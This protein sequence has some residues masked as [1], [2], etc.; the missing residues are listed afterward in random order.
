MAA[1]KPPGASKP[2]LADYSAKRDFSRTAE[3][4]PAPARPRRGKLAFV[5]QKHDARRL[6]FDLRL[7]LDGVL[8]SWAVTRG[9]SMTPG[10]R[11]LAVQTEDH[12]M[13]Y[14]AWEGVI[15]Q[16]QYGGGTMIVWDRGT[17]L[18]EGDARK[19][20]AKGRLTFR[21][22]GER[23]KGTWSLVRM[24]DE[25]K[26]HNWLLI[27]RSDENALA[28]GGAEPVDTDMASVISGKSNAEIAGGG[29]L[30]PDHK[31]RARKT[32][33][34]GPAALARVKGAKKDI[35]PP[36][37]APS[38]ALQVARPPARDGWI[39]EIK[40]DGYRIEARLDAGKV[41]LLTRKGLD[42]TRRFPTVA[43]AVK[44]LAARTALLD[45]E[46]IVQD[47]AG[48]TSF[49]GLQSDLKAGRHDRMVYYAFDLLH[50]DGFDL[51]GAPLVERKR[52][53]AEIIAQSPGN[54]ALRYNDHI[55]EA[56]GDILPQACRLG[57]E[58]IV[59]KQLAL[60]Y[61]SGRGEHWVKSKCMLR[62]EFVVLGFLPA[63]DRKDAVGSLVLGYYAGGRL[64]H[65]G[66]AGTG[67]SAD[68]ARALFNRFSAM[69]GKAPDFGNAVSRAAARGVVWV[70][71][72]AVAE[73]EYRGRTADGLLRQAAFVG[74]REDKPASE[75][76]LEQDPLFIPK[77]ADPDPDPAQPDFTHPERVMWPEAGVT[78]QDLGDYYV[79]VAAW[80][81]PHVSH[82]VLS[83]VR[84]PDGAAAQ[85][86]FAKHAW[87]GLD[88]AIHLADTGE[89]KPMMEIGDLRGLLALVQMNVLE[90]HVWGSRIGDLD[91]PDRLIFDLDPGEGVTWD[92]VKAS[93]L[94]MRDRLKE[95]G[96]RSFLKTSGGKGLHVTVPLLPDLD[97]DAAKAF[98]RLV[99]QQ[100]AADDPTRYVAT[101]AKSRRKGRIFIDYLRNGR[102]ATAVAP[103]STRAR[104]GAPVAMPIDW[105]EL[106]AL[107]SADHYTVKNAP[108]RLAKRDDPWSEMTKIRQKLKL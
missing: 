101:M 48:Q 14:K 56:G 53:L 105:S 27:K 29:D 6:H 86:F 47:E 33:V 31:A 87:M 59:S 63:S 2:Q 25:G 65:A 68:D 92:D 1:R 52:L 11:R 66:R 40:H 51:R 96:L 107:P 74:L 24:K 13:A 79:A 49:S 45:G 102:G 20:L 23:L 80:I 103:Y 67:F 97:W 73:I 37:V 5:V 89:G 54:F 85:C 78:K 72:E 83:L 22:D 16:G 35:L 55:A 94:D 9:P 88:P 91:R 104:A 82:R 15:P 38:L 99:A 50:L 41:K 106:K 17:W 26:R 7:E 21:L 42:W 98:T 4:A 18:P 108:A 100:M 10:I 39:H 81:L 34:A 57:L 28:P 71:P 44:R 64:M 93:A 19:G 61:V 32:S 36:F 60:P 90:I 75:V 8:K 62:Q 58:G 43:E 76:V 30:R 12:P 70:R 69:A 46:I 95:L 3:P 84:C 77:H